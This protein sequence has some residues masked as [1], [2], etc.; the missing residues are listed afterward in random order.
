MTQRYTA[1]DREAA[2]GILACILADP[3][4]SNADLQQLLRA[5]E[6][7]VKRVLTHLRRQGKVGLVRHGP[8]LKPR[9]YP[10]EQARALLNQYAAEALEKKRERNR[11]YSRKH[12][13]AVRAGELD[14]RDDGRPI[15]RRGD[16]HA[17]LPFECRAPAS[18]FHLGGG[19]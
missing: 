14:D 1:A 17:P 10:P 4:Q 13:A 11:K 9:W 6:Y 16:A 18:V 3:G 12:A 7:R 15:R 8:T 5:P 19:L 2:P